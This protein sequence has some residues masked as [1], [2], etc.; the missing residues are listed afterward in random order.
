MTEQE[1][2]ESPNPGQL[3]EYMAGRVSARKVRLVLCGCLRSPKVWA[4]LT[5]PA[6]RRAVEVAEA[7]ADGAATLQELGLAR[8]RANTAA[9]RLVIW[10]PLS[11]FGHAPYLANNV[12]LQDG[13]LLPVASRLSARLGQLRPPAGLIRDVLGNP[14]R[15]PTNPPAACLVPSLSIAQAAYDERALPA[16]TL[17]PV[18]LQILADA[19]EDAGCT[20]ANLLGHLRGPGPHVRGCWALDL[21]LGKS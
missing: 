10:Q 14:F 8:K 21:I 7:F 17:D 3:L 4:Q 19:L 9:L 1:W 2:L 20:D 16:G 13:N 15:P 6:S 12:C 11:L 18:R 5:A